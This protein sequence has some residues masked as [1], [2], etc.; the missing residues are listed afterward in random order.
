MTL[1][2]INE[3]HFH[4]YPDLDKIERRLSALITKGEKLMSQVSDDVQKLTDSIAKLQA[5]EAKI[6]AIVA[7]AQANAGNVPADLQA[8]IDAELQEVDTA[9]AGVPATP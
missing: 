9:D 1:I 8:A 2:T 4:E 5:L 3:N 6:A 7:A